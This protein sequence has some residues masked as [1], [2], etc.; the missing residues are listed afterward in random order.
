MNLY[1]YQEAGVKTLLKRPKVLLA[2]D[3]GLGKTAQAIVAIKRLFD[4]HLID[5]VLIVVPSTLMAVWKNEISKWAPDLSPVIYSGPNRFG[6][7]E[8]GMKILI[9]SYDTVSRDLKR[10]S[11]DGSLIDIGVDLIIADEAH[12][13]KN[14]DSQRWKTLSRILSAR[15]W[16]LTGTPLENNVDE[17]VGVLRFLFQ[18]ELLDFDASKHIPEVLK[19]RD[20]SMVRR[21]KKEVGLELP[22]KRVVEVPVKMHPSQ[23]TEY[24][25]IV[26][27]FHK[28]C[29]SGSS[30]GNK[31]NLLAIIQKLRR[32]ATISEEGESSKFDLIEQEVE[33]LAMNDEKVV[34]FSSFA[35]LALEPLYERL[36]KH[37]AVM[38][39]GGMS[40]EEVADAD[41]KFREDSSINV[42]CASLKSAGVGFTWTVANYAFILDLWWNP[43]AMRQAE[44]RLYRIGQTSPVLIKRLYSEDSI[45]EAILQILGRKEKLFDALVDDVNL[46]TEDEVTFDDLID[47]IKMRK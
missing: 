41:E 30:G 7:L 1:P 16:A 43:Q 33:R 46:P 35:G 25:L 32:I 18:N 11:N 27:E 10:R 37:G 3:M 42:M 12:F 47:L 15:R 34:I 17:L 40:S 20:R 23:E 4:N 14:V 19:L 21:T 24:A 13:M 36:K 26:D 9:G 2:D 28:E 8:G 45:D 44:D 22:P 6:M 31:A 29:K 38:I 39:R 5:R